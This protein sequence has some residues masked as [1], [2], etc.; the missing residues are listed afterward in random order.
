MGLSLIHIWTSTVYFEKAKFENTTGYRLGVTPIEDIA[1]VGF[2][3]RGASEDSMNKP[4][5]I[6]QIGFS[7]KNLETNDPG[8]SIAPLQTLDTYHMVPSDQEAV[9]KLV[10]QHIPDVEA[11]NV[12]D[13]GIIDCLLYTS[14]CRLLVKRFLA[15]K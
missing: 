5:Y 2:T 1:S 11:V 12:A 9:E 15:H 7:G 8:S 14:R 6:D 3:W 4:F 10:N 13:A